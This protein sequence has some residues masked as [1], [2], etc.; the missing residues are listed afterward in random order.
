MESRDGYVKR[1]LALIGAAVFLVSLSMTNFGVISV[2]M[3]LPVLFS[4]AGI[5]MII[6]FKLRAA[7]L[8][9][10]IVTVSSACLCFMMHENRYTAASGFVGDNKEIVGYVCKKSDY[11]CGSNCTVNV[12]RIN[13]EKTDFKVMVNF[14]NIPKDE[15]TQ[16]VKICFHANLYDLKNKDKNTKYLKS[17]GIY[18]TGKSED[19]SVHVC[20]E[21][22][23]NF[24]YYAGLAKNKM[25]RTV[26]NFLPNDN[27]K[28]I[29]SF[30]FGD[31]SELSNSI[32]AN[33]KICGITHLMAV[34]GLH[35]YT[36]SHVI[37][38]MLSR[39]LSSRKSAIGSILF[40]V[41]FMGMTDFT[42][43]V[44]RSG[45]MMIFVYMAEILWRRADSLN[46][47]GA[48]MIVMCAQNPFSA[49]DI[50]LQLSFSA[51]VGLAIFG[52]KINDMKI[53]PTSIKALNKTVEFVS[54]SSLV[55]LTA[56]V[57]TLP[58]MVFRL[59]NISL[60]SIASNI[61]CVDLS[62]FAMIFGGFG[63]VFSAF[64][65]LQFLGYPLLIAAGFIAK[66]ILKIVS[67]LSKYDFLYINIDSQYCKAIVVCVA[68]MIG[69]V[70]I[71]RPQIFKNKGQTALLVINTAAVSAAVESLF[72]K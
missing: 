7:V 62:M 70:Y 16:Q 40:I 52:G 31:K 29:I 25:C 27:G 46:S 6:R 21:K 54:K 61:L 1:P 67:A 20:K 23:N 9:A 68:V 72:I 56:T 30:V 69:V 4:V 59:P 5:I 22:V 47:M 28:L 34:S 44:V 15:I 12:K 64:S 13:Y 43:S 53:Q 50:G 60:L 11:Y 24:M 66:I 19:E 42:P 35:M 58:V 36:W 37:Y 18:L 2:L 32:R 39:V 41:F 33:F 57:F 38:M 55:C 45:T 63:A 14:A 48:A 10:M 71:F 65:F 8:V 26:Q 3:L 51:A 49:Y 17:Q